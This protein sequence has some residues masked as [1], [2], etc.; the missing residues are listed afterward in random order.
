[1]KCRQQDVAE[2]YLGNEKDILIDNSN[3]VTLV[4]FS[5]QSLLIFIAITGVACWL[6]VSFYPF[7]PLYAWL[8]LTATVFGLGVRVRRCLLVE[9]AAAMLLIGVLSIPVIVMEGHPVSPYRLQRIQVG[10][11]TD[12]VRAALGEP[13]E[14][15][16]YDSAETWL[17]SG[18]TWC[19]VRVSIDSRGVVDS[20]AHDH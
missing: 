19:T 14:I 3:N 1:M 7:G 13:T 12:E 4:R 10:S 15:E 6:F 2:I 16:P 11:T 18:P 8:L 9:G 20:F 17:Y 5:F